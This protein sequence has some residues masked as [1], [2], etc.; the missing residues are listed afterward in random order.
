MAKIKRYL[1]SCSS[2]AELNVRRL[3]VWGGYNHIRWCA[4]TMAEAQRH[5]ASCQREYGCINCDPQVH[6]VDLTRTKE[7]NKQ[8]LTNPKKV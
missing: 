7:T 8:K 3:Y 5:I 1:I 6:T 2:D 4:E